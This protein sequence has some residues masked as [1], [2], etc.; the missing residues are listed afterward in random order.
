MSTD[1]SNHVLAKRIS[2]KEYLTL[3]NPE[4]R[5]QT[6]VDDEGNYK[7]YWSV[8]NNYYYTENNLYN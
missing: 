5:G 1:Y 4:F 8:G 2:A 3:N 7:M 6:R